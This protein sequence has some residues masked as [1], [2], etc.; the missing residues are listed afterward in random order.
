MFCGGS[1]NPVPMAVN[2]PFIK[3]PSGGPSEGEFVVLQKLRNQQGLSV[4]TVGQGR[5][6]GLLYAVTK[7]W[8]RWQILQGTAL[9]CGLQLHFPEP[10]T[11]LKG[12][13]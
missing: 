13:S 9:T 7:S 10:Q 12:Q 1:L 5:S 3:D 11:K 2:S 4:T 6:V 8:G